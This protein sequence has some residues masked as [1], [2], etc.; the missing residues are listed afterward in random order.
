[1]NL[2]MLTVLRILLDLIPKGVDTMW[3]TE[4]SKCRR[5]FFIKHGK[6]GNLD[7][8]KGKQWQLTN[9]METKTMLL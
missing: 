4:K 1:M 7:G 2:L 5:W 8:K 9:M 6:G 3:R